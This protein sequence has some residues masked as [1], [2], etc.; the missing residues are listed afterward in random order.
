MDSHCLNLR[1]LRAALGGDIAGAQVLCPGPNHSKRD[2]SLAVKPT[3]TG[4]L[5]FSHAGDDWRECRNYVY[6]R[7]G[8]QRERWRDQPQTFERVRHQ[9]EP[10]Q[11]TECAKAIWAEGQDPPGTLAE[12]YLAA[13]KLHLPLEVLGSVLR[14]HPRCPWKCDDKF[15]SIPCL[16]AAF[17]SIDNNDVVTAIHRIRVDRPERWPKTE[18]KMLGDVRGSAIKLDPPGTRLA[19]AEGVETA[20]AARQLG[21][22]ATWALGSARNFEPI[23]GVNELIILGEHDAASRK[24]VDACSELWREHG[25]DVFLALPTTGNDFNDYLI[26]AG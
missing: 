5:V 2:R 15:I 21:F 24:A 16:I 11:N 17:T 10:R 26:G 22:G 12:E 1:T 14:F 9:S 13:R 8:W 23:D 3:A 4:V 19:I 18:R 20:L 7:L 6:Q 25:R